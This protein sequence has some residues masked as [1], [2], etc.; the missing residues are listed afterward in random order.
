[1]ATIQRTDERG[2][3]LRANLSILSITGQRKQ[4]ELISA[5]PKFNH[6]KHLRTS[7][8]EVKKQDKRSRQPI[9]YRPYG[10]R[11]EVAVHPGLTPWANECQ[12]Y[13]LVFNVA[14]R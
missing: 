2:C 1:M 9:G 8:G 4:A 13:G 10:T 14:L 5:D 7:V 12:P 11:V 6:K 3:G